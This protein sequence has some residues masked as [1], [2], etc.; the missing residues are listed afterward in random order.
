MNSII[1]WLYQ[2]QMQSQLHVCLGTYHKNHKD[3]SIEFHKKQPT[4]QMYQSSPRNVNRA[5]KA[6][7]PLQIISIDLVDVENFYKQREN[8][9]KSVQGKFIWIILL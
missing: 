5:L 9:L 6:N 2:D 4:Y 3:H 7:K 8:N 1:A